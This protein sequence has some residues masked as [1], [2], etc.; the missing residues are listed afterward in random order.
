MLNNKVMTLIKNEGDAPHYY[1]ATRTRFSPGRETHLICGVDELDSFVGHG[2]HDGWHLLHLFCRLLG[3]HRKI[4]QKRQ[5][6][7]TMTWEA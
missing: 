5:R 7:A 3:V 1:P 2:E 4:K 6:Q